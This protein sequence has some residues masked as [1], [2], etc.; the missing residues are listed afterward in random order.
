MSL[1]SELDAVEHFVERRSL[2]DPH[3]FGS[4]E[5]L[6]RLTG[7]LSAPNE[8]LVHRFGHVSNLYVGHA[9]IIHAFAATAHCTRFAMQ[10]LHGACSY[11]PQHG[12]SS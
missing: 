4:E 5:L 6:Q 7:E 10:R 8:R 1:G 9:C 11:T 3:E 12:M 2:R